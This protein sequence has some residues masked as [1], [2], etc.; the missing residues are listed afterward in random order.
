MMEKSLL[1]AS[2]IS[3]SSAGDIVSGFTENK[4]CTDA[5]DMIESTQA[6]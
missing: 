4:M 3:F 1:I 6:V 2:V 5:Y